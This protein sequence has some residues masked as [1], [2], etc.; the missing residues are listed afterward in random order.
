MLNAIGVTAGDTVVVHGASG[1][2]G[3]SAVQQ[4]RLL[5]ARVV[6]TASKTSFPL[7]R[8]FGATPVA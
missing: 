4:L 5:G 3:V 6:G 7:V 2:T 8:S 1:A